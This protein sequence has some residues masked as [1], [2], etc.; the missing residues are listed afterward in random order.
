[1]VWGDGGS[2]ATWFSPDPEKTQ[3]TNM[4]PVTG[5]H[6]CLGYHPEYVKKDYAEIVK[7]AGGAP[8]EWQDI[9][10]SLLATGDPTAALADFRANSAFPSEER[11]DQGA[12]LPLDRHLAALGVTAPR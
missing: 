3:G 9:I 12:H 7:R 6:V 8:R 11:R 2:Y 5:G 1:M 4:L 10:F